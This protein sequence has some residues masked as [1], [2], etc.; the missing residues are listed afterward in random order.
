MVL[1]IIRWVFGYVSFSIT[2]KGPE[3]FLNLAAR[4]GFC[5]WDIQKKE[6]CHQAR[7]TRKEYRNL[8]V[9]A[10]KAKVILRV[11][12]RYG[13]P[14]LLKKWKGKR[15]LLY[16]TG[17]AIAVLILLSMRVWSIDVVGNETLSAYD[18]KQAAA[19]CGL[20]QG[21]LKK[22]LEPRL[23]QQRLMARFPEIGWVAINTWGNTATIRLDEGLKIPEVEDTDKATNIMS[24]MDGQIVRMDVYHGMPEVQIGDAVTEGQLLISG[25]NQSEKGEES[26]VHASA[27]IMAK[28]RR[29]FSVEIPLE[30]IKEEPSGEVLTRRSL[31]VFGAD[32]PLSLQGL[33]EGSYT[34]TVESKPL[35]LNGVELP[36]TFHEEIFTL[37]NQIPITLT[38]E[39]AKAKA[40]EE[41]KKKQE[42][43]LKND[44]EDGKVLSFTERERVE[45]GS[46]FLELDCVCEE[47]IAVE[48]EILFGN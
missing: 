10:R 47:N 36:V 35:I 2:G 8:R 33:P 41:I 27:K 25:I 44:L 34:R 9:S 19:E 24:T 31:S 11:E 4:D 18:I 13:L 26:F 42:E 48:Q 17:G 1:K 37:Q 46:Y 45:N 40:M 5:L 7:I 21:M 30:Q 22:D 38:K 6:D 23:V 12:K 28:T 16:G 43:V 3:R 15:G 14:F 39:E 29:I 32:L 20:Y